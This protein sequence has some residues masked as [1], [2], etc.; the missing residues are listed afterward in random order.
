M[1]DFKQRNRM[2]RAIYAKPTIIAIALL[3]ALVAHGAWGMYQKSKEAVDKTHVATERLKQLEVRE[4]ELSGDILNLSTE[5][6]IE[7]EIRDRF[8]VAKEGESVMIVADPATE[9]VHTVTVADETLGV[10]QKF[11]GA[12]GI[13]N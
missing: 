10:M 11:L 1:L 7:G 2:R 4:K 8:M 6:G 3:L 9:K 12:V 5:R 13:S